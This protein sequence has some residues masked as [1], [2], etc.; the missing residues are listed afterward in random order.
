[1]PDHIHAVIQVGSVD[2]V[3]VVRS[4]KAYVSRRCTETGL[5][6]GFW[7]ERFHDRGIREHEDMSRWVA[8][9]TNNPVEA[10]L[11]EYWDEYPWIGG[12]LLNEENQRS[13]G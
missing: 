11:V 13:S 7:Q 3:S 10:G 9:I 6:A 4:I 5:T 8:Y 1:M 12:E 2:L